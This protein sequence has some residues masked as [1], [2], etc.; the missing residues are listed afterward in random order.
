MTCMDNMHDIQYVIAI[1][2]VPC[3]RLGFFE[4]GGGLLFLLLISLLREL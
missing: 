4:K 3:W 1:I 2:S